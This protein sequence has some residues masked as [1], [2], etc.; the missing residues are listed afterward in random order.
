MDAI[1]ATNALMDSAAQAAERKT[2]VH[3]YIQHHVLYHVADG[4]ASVWNLPFIRIPALDVFRHDEVMLAVAVVVLVALFAFLYRRNDEV[5]HGWG[6]LLEL[7]VLFVRDQIVRP[8]FTEE[9][10]RRFAPIFCAFF[11]LILTLN[12][13]GLVPLFSAATSNLSVTG[14]LALV[15]GT[16]MVGMSIWR[17]GILGFL[18]TFVPAGTPKILL[19]LLVPMEVISLGTRVFALAVRLFANVLSGHI[20]IFVLVSMAVLFGWLGSPAILLAVAIYFFE[21]F[22]SILQAFIFSML[23]AIFISQMIYEHH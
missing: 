14:A 16:F 8:A 18:K 5:Q 10:S 15:S 3:E 7:F 9:D 17:K 20:L 21:I 1:A 2:L 12:L 13:L 11:F 4:N 23:S 6:N 22:M 19:P